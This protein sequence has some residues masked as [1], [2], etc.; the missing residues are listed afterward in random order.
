MA[1]CNWADFEVDLLGCSCV[2][3]MNSC[4]LVWCCVRSGDFSLWPLHTFLGSLSRLVLAKLQLT[5]PSLDAGVRIRDAEYFR[6]AIFRDSYTFRMARIETFNGCSG[7]R[8]TCLILFSL[9][10]SLVDSLIYDRQ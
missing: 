6:A 8:G 3:Y 2:V 5:S 9:L 7:C 4:M 1:L 10:P